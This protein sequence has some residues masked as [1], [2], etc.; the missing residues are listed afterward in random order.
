MELI[1]FHPEVA[2][3]NCQHCL[4][5]LYDEETG[6]VRTFS[7]REDLVERLPSVPAPCRTSKGCPKG[8]PENPKK[9]SLKNLKAY[10]HWKECKAV[11]QFPDDDIVRRNAALIQEIVDMSN[12]HKQM[13]MMS[14]YML[15]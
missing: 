12:E 15:R 2:F 4:K 3:R 7:S 1:L 11:G 9:L 10:Q 5:Y 8:T 13:Q 6:K 14:L